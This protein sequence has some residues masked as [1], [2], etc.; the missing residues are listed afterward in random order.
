MSST[1]TNFPP[2]YVNYNAGPHVVRIM[3]VVIVLATIFV[4]LRIIVR[5]HRRVGVALDDWL[6]IAS[7]VFLWLEYAD[8]YLCIDRGG[9]GLH[10]PIALKTKTDA[11]RN[12]FIYMF[13]GELLFFTCLALIKLSVLAMYYRIFP[14]RFMKW[15]CAVLGSMTVAWWIAVM[16]VTVFQCLPIHK[17]WDLATPGKCV[18]ANIFYISTN[19]V[20]NIIM[21]AM[22]L[23][24]PTYEV[25][26]LHVSRKMKFAIGA[27]FLVGA[28]V[29]IASIIKL[30]V[31][32][33]L[34]YLGPTADVTY[35][36]ADL[37]IWVE[38]EPAVGI[39]SA[40]LPTLRPILT[41]LFRKVGL[42][43]DASEHAK[44]PRKSLV[45]F[46]RGDV[47]NK[48]RSYTMTESIDQDQDSMENLSGW[49]EEQ[50]GKRTTTVRVGNRNVELNHMRA[51][52]PNSINVKT[53]MAWK[54]FP[55]KDMR[56]NREAK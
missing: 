23:C 16:L 14:T 25:Y 2:E 10:L 13:A 38:V 33:N 42:T 32:V 7:L 17:Y 26:K 43:Q 52:Q 51:D 37:I 55:A 20:P 50:H 12:V 56:E 48:K 49:P 15:G 27:N 4:A 35:Y 54:E 44:S 36:L 24:L 30:K 21:D 6:S 53:E 28:L 45:T 46:G 22:I 34:Y 8:G 47:R 1:S 40:S 31:M 39:I 5:V 11:L 41:L 18:N 29:I 9:V 19:G 3:T